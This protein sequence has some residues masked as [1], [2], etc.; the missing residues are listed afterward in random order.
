MIQGRKWLDAVR[1][2]FVQKPVVEIEA[3]WI[4]RTGSFREDTRPSNRKPIGLCSN[5][6]HQLNVFLVQMIMVG[7]GVAITVIGDRPPRVSETVPDRWAATVFVDGPL[8]LIG[9]SSRTPQKTV[10]KTRGGTSILCSVFLAQ[11]SQTGPGRQHRHSKSRPACNPAKL[12]AGKSF[13]KSF[14]WHHFT[15][16]G[17]IDLR[18]KLA[19]DASCL[20]QINITAS[21]LRRNCAYG[22]VNGSTCLPRRGK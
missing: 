21:A 1:R 19:F 22:W 13:G 15:R 7:R 11:F 14:E 17:G 16:R 2:Q 10:R 18:Q 12:A 8:D 20:K 4:R 3:I 6:L 9:G 5:N